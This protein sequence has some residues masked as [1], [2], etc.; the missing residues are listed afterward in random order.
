MGCVLSAMA[1]LL[2][3]VPVLANDS[4]RKPIAVGP[5]TLFGLVEGDFDYGCGMSVY[6]PM[7]AGHAGTIV[8]A[9][10]A[11]EALRI[12][13]DGRLLSLPLTKD[14]STTPIK[15]G[16]TQTVVFGT[17]DQSA[18][19]ALKATRICPKGAQACVNTR[20]E[21]TLQLKVGNQIGTLPVYVEDGC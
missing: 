4:Q 12:F 5:L 9:W 20:Y 14:F 8:A 7:S 3:T 10:P 16:G 19:F 17:S 18:T 1:L 11:G 21:G 15:V 13:M 6:T 2:V